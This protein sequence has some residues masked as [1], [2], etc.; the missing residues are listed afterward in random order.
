MLSALPLA[1]VTKVMDMPLGFSTLLKLIS[2]K[3]SWSFRA[4]V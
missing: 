1:D 3:T 4:M 2:G